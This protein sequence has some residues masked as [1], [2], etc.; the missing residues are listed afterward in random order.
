MFLD[1]VCVIS[2]CK[3]GYGRRGCLRGRRT[4]L[5]IY[6]RETHVLEEAVCTVD[7]Q[8]E[9]HSSLLPEVP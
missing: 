2:Y 7:I 3:L 6:L 4:P 8:K 9:Q 5:E 1:V